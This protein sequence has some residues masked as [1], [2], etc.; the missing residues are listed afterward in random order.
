ML[1][2]TLYFLFLPAVQ[3]QPWIK[4]LPQSKEKGEMSL[5]DYQ[6]AFNT[7]WDPFQVDRGFYYE[8]G[9]K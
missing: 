2:Y 3:A 5:S 8:N 7:Y 6:K 9:K 1:I 4:H